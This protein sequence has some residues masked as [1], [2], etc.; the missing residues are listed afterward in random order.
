MFNKGEI[1]DNKKINSLSNNSGS[2]MATPSN[3]GQTEILV[4][5]GFIV[6]AVVAIALIPETGGTSL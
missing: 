3:N 1:Y 4:C 2:Y 6:I 5:I